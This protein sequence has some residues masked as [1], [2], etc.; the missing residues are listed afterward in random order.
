[1]KLK[2]R[3]LFGL[4]FIGLFVLV[5]V[6]FCFTLPIAAYR[7]DVYSLIEENS[8]ARVLNNPAI[9]DLAAENMKPINSQDRVPPSLLG[10]FVNRTEWGCPDGQSSPRWRTKYVNVSH[11]IIH[12]TATPNDETNWTQRVWNIWYYHANQTPMDEDGDGDVDSRGWGDIGYNY[13]IDPDGTIYEGR[14]G[15]DNVIGAYECEGDVV[16][17]HAYGHNYGTMGVAFIGTYIDTEPTLEALN[18]AVSLIAWKCAQRDINPLGKGRD[19]VGKE[20]H[21]IAGHRDVGE[22]TCP[23]DMLYDLLPTIRT[24][25]AHQLATPFP[26]ELYENHAPLFINGDSEFIAQANAEGWPGNGSSSNPFIIDGLRITGDGSQSLI[27]INNTDVYFQISKCILTD[28]YYG[29][30]FDNVRHVH[31]TGNMITNN[32][33]GCY[34]SSSGDNIFTNNTFSNNFVGLVITY[35]SYNTF[36]AGNTFTN[37]ELYGIVLYNT[38]PDYKTS[39]RSN[40]ISTIDS[41]R[42]LTYSSSWGPFNVT[43]NS[44]IDNYPGGYSQ[45]SN[46]I[47]TATSDVFTDFR[48]NY[49]D[50]WISP[51]ANA[52]GFVDLPYNIT[53]AFGPIEN[54][55]PYPL[56]NP[57]LLTNPVISSP[58]DG[59]IYSGN[60]TIMWQ[61]AT[62]SHDHGITYSLYYS[63]ESDRSWKPL[64][65]EST[66]I[67]Y[68][69]D[70]T[71]VLDNP[72]YWIKVVASCSG[73]SLAVDYSDYSFA[74]KNKASVSDSTPPAA[75][76][77]SA[78]MDGETFAA[79][80]VILQ[81]TALSDALIYQ[82]QVASSSLF[83]SLEIS[84]VV[85]NNSRSL[86]S[87]ND[88]TYFWRVKA[89]DAAGNWGDWSDSWSFTIMTTTSQSSSQPSSGWSIPVLLL[90]II[91]VAMVRQRKKKVRK[92]AFISNYQNN[93][94]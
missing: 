14:A 3:L 78:P 94:S 75:P 41:S 18:S 9:P 92:N 77:L 42:P 22:T 72:T 46:D 79:G 33:R 56:T 32:S 45:A 21:F 34:H 25:V 19:Y 10:K 39:S 26:G 73:R 47:D 50:D 20:Y 31:I 40:S 53:N 93:R 11:I 59:G 4:L 48:Y 74:I 16:G 54:Q 28:G 67:S 69:W 24:L 12:H 6:I 52:D 37:N 76:R 13:L 43:W 38:F 83:D 63:T 23:G 61:P 87:L 91:A 68:R 27:N 82:V 1:M 17:A 86:S 55:D 71:E 64:I 85:I 84:S 35:H 65:T 81:W 62:D 89:R 66:Q 30:L 44:F 7:S 60:M 88:S 49:W 57:H 58:N 80:T 70:T 51:D 2:R 8:R 29:I 90:A 36:I 5:L 15:G